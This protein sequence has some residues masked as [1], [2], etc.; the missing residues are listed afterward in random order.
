MVQMG[1]LRDQCRKTSKPA[2]LAGDGNTFGGGEELGS[3][4]EATGFRNANQMG[5]PTYPSRHPALALDFILYSQGIEMVD[6]SVPR[7]RF[8]DH[9]PLV[10]DFLVA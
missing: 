3:L 4:L 8:S 9:L 2:I 10:C 5:C 7:V 1:E 6:F